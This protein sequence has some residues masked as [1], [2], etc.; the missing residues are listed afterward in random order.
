MVQNKCRMTTTRNW[1]PIVRLKSKRYIGGGA[2][3]RNKEILIAPRSTLVIR[4]LN[5]GITSLTINIQFYLT[6]WLV[7]GHSNFNSIGIF[8]TTTN[9]QSLD[10]PDLNNLVRPRQR[11]IYVGPRISRAAEARWQGNLHELQVGMMVATLAG[12]DETGY[13]FWIVKNYRYY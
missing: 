11:D 13:P 8:L 10:N 1:L 12:G 6:T 3:R 2:W 4:M 5:D 7:P 9:V